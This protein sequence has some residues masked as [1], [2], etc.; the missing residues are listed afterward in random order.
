MPADL[1]CHSK[2]S[3]GSTEVDELVLLAKNKGLDTLSVT[4]HDTLAG[5]DRAAVFG[6]KF[7]VRIIKGVEI[8]CFD[9]ERKRNVHLLCYLPSSRE[10]LSSMLRTVNRN[11][12]QAVQLAIQ[13][14]MRAYPIPYDMI[15]RRSAGSNTLFKQHIMRALMDAGYTNEMFGDVYRKLFDS[16]FGIARVDFEHPDIFEGL[17]I[18]RESGGVAVLAHPA[19]YDSYDIIPELIKNGLDGIE[20]SYP[21]AREDD[22]DVLGRICDEYGLIRTG[23]TDF[24]GGNGSA[25]HPLGTCTTSDE[26][27]GKIIALAGKRVSDTQKIV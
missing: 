2:I 15:L 8:S 12:K 22:E 1:H 26:E 9:Y 23:G 25:P 16:R 5:S 10:R 3:D 24:H 7:G 4:D 17:R 21:R 20:I 27:V 13:K 6:E 19:V 14:V 11:R 18:V